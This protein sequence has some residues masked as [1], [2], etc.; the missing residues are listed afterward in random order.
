[1]FAKL[2]EFTRK[3]RVIITAV[4]LAGAAIMF[5]AAPKLS[6]VGV[7]DESQFLPQNTESTTANNL[8]K[9][10]FVSPTPTSPSNVILVIYDASGLSNTDTQAAQDINTWLT[11]SAAPKTIQSVTSVFENGALKATLVSSDQTTMMMIVNFS[12][13]G[14]DT[15]AKTGLQQIQDYIT[16]NHPNLQAY[17]T[18]D[19]AI[20]QDMTASVQQ[21]IDRTTIVTIILVAILLLII[22][23]SPIAILLPLIAIGASFGVASGVISYLAQAGVK[24]S[25]L[26]QAYLVV[27]I[28]GVGTDYCLFMVSRF[29]EELRRKELADARANAITQIT[30]VIAASALTVIVAFMSMGISRFGMNKTTGYALA[31]GVGVTLLAGLTLVPAL[32]SLFGKYLFWPG[33]PAAVKK[34]GRF[35][36]HVIG[37]WVSQHPI[38]VAVPIVVILLIPYAAL[39]NLKRTADVMTQLPQ[40]AESVKGFK[41][42]NSHFPAGELSPLY[43]LI[44]SPQGNITSDAS[45]QSIDNLTRSLQKVPG[46]ASVDYY[47]APSSQLTPLAAQIRSI[48]DAIGQGSGLDQLSSV[49]AS[50]QVL[51]GLALQYPGILQSPNFRQAEANLTQVGTIAAQLSASS[52][53]DVPP[54][55]TPLQTAI[56]NLSDNFAAL[57]NE[58]NLQVSTP[59]TTFL[60]KTYFSTDKTIARINIVLSDDPYSS[61]AMA[62]VA[63]IRKEVAVDISTTTLS[64]SSTYVG[65]QSAVQADIMAVSDSD[66]LKVVGLAILGILIVIIILL[67]S[68]LA[69]LYMVATVLLNYG[70]TLGLTAWIFLDLAKQ[71]ALIYMIPLFIFVILVALGADYNIFLVS[72]IREEAQQRPTKEAVSHAVANTGGVITACGIILAGTFATL[73]TA[74]LQVVLQIGVAIPAGVLIDTFIVRALLVPSL[75]TLA[76]RWSWW[77]SKLFRR[78]YKQ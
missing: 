2:A 9:E 17:L 18:G 25:T 27:V 1:M 44:E 74:P 71:G 63:R 28:F 66:F 70:T 57:V 58:F 48:G 4:W 62:D 15:A 65:G 24:F 7:T 61:T 30:P 41:I 12:V 11:S 77:P 68:L 43:L 38:W 50:A 51:Q 47:S 5:L 34:E 64:G 13:S 59:F 60:E 26:T 75:A 54:L 56:D 67:R 42:L 37:N 29:R 39:P 21:T 14:L 40:Q 36:W 19:T 20:Y 46:V 3:Y 16:Q 35:G 73:I 33:N 22:Y 10:K 52:P 32:M 76:G 45:L 53:A 8:L 72:R 55:L 31:I 69:P 23:R 78:S 49:Q 6:N